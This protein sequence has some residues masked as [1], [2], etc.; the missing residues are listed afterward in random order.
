MNRSH[1][2]LWDSFLPAEDG[3]V[4]VDWVVLTAAIVALCLVVTIPAYMSSK[5]AGRALA[6]R[7][8]LVIG[9]A[10]AD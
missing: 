1:A 10:A 4:M 5:G 8:V 7:L 9:K 3:A 2:A 6:D